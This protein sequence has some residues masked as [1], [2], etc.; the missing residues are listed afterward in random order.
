MAVLLVNNA[1]SRLAASVAADALALS[2]SPGDGAKFPSPT[3]DDWFPLTL[4]RADG[5]REIV[6]CNGRT[7]D[8]LAVV[9][10]QEGTAAV[11]LASGDRVEVRLTAAALNT[12]FGGP[13]ATPTFGSL[14]V[15]ALTPYVDF[16][17]GNSAD[18]Y[19]SRIIAAVAGELVIRSAAK[20]QVRFTDAKMIVNGDIEAKAGSYTGML[21]RKGPGLVGFNAYRDDASTNSLY[22]AQTTA[23]SIYFGNIDG[24]GFG[25]GGTGLG[26]ATV[27]NGAASVNGTFWAQ[28][29]ISSGGHLSATGNVYAGDVIAT[30]RVYSAGGN[31]WLATDGNVYGSL[32]GGYLSTFLGSNYTQ[33]GNI[34]NDIANFAGG[35]GGVGTYAFLLIGGGGGISPGSL[36]AGA[37]TR[38]AGAGY[39]AG[40]APGGT[41]RLMGAI[42]N[43]DGSDTDSITLCLRVA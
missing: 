25:I 4:I 39:S 29:T 37:N 18:D 31:S 2:V 26:W 40:Y 9:R 5:I 13:T 28:G 23:G 6:R 30:N 43:A 32:W 20:E 36:V 24:S 33:R 3:G 34:G 14:E 7:G 42:E 41:W 15:S 10:A 17:A 16:H 27:R 22:Q 8:V 19:T 1:I 35:A 21:T 11:P 38:W 12:L